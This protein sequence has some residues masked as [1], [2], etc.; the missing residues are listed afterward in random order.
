MQLEKYI[1]ELLYRYDCITVP[2]FGAFIANTKGAQVHTSTNAFYPPTKVI[3][4]NTQITGNDGLLA[5]YIAD[6]EAMSYEATLLKIENKVF[7]WKNALTNNELITL[8]NIGEF[9]L[10]EDG[11]LQFS[12]S[13]HTN[14]LTGSFGLSSFVTAPV[15]REVLHKEVEVLEEKVPVLITPEA[16]RRPNYLR[17]AA[18]VTISLAIAGM[19]GYRYHTNALNE[20]FAVAEQ[21]A[22]TAVDQQIQQATF[23]NDIPLELSPV[24]VTIA[25]KEDF[26][27]HIVAGA[28]RTE[29]NATTKVNELQTRGYEKATVLGKNKYGL[30]QVSLQGFHN[31]K[32]AYHLLNQVNTKEEGLWLYIIN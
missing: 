25:K 3:S 13:Q 12:P 14:Y 6:S 26:K 8:K 24:Q 31:S 1:S 19:F 23:F 9:W 28:F 10:S 22:Q 5:K 16:R 29:E 27:Y 30:W 20:Q 2:G 15:I 7:E 32:E 4:F 18:V 17:Y 11:K 21:N